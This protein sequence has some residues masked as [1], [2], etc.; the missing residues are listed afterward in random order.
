MNTKLNKILSR[1]TPDEA[2]Y[3][4]KLVW[5]DGLTDLKNRRAFDYEIKKELRRA[6]NIGYDISLLMIDIDD[7]KKVNDT[8]GHQKGDEVLR[9][10]SLT[11]RDNIKGSDNIY[12]YGGE[13][14]A[15][16]LPNTC[17][18][19]SLL[20]SDRVRT[21]ITREVGV[22]VSIGISNYRQTSHDISSLIKHSDV[23]LY[24]A[25]ANGKNQSII[26]GEKL[27]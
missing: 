17:S 19:I 20:I 25:K 7:F 24:Q 22:T 12:R 8:Y 26:Y 23:A 4:E 27:K 18:V 1:L 3:V 10:V 2:A 13:E 6:D 9:N 16:L 5:K 15:V 11:I 14:I 21:A